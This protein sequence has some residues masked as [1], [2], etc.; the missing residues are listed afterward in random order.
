MPPIETDEKAQASVL[1]R[2]KM[3][4][5]DERTK[6]VQTQASDIGRRA[7]TAGSFCQYLRIA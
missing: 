4:G 7:I 6:T 2:S 1:E 3:Q 5:E